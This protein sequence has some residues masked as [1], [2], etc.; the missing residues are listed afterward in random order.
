MK[1]QNIRVSVIIPCHNAE[2][3]ILKAIN[4]VLAGSVLPYEILVYD[5]FSEDRTVKVIEENFADNELVSLCRG[6]KNRGAGFARQEL[7]LKAKGNFIAFL[8]AD[9]WWYPTKLEQ[10]ISKV[11]SENCDIV[12]CG[13]D[14]FSEYGN[15]L[16]RRLPLSA[17]NVW[18]MHLSN[19]LA[20]SMTIFRK[21][22]CYATEMPQ[23]RKRQD[24]GFW[25]KIFK[26]NRKLTCSVIKE[27]L[28]GYL[29]RSNS[30]S[31]DKFDNIRHNYNMFREVLKYNRF[32]SGFL[33]F[34]NIIVRLL[35]A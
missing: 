6:T 26:N 5:D 17:I 23:I 35:R 20:T 8:D 3:T 11:L 34:L 29:R 19:W 33:V 21:D 1:E 22:L 2:R 31:S 16:G 10:Q 13:Y 9:D 15:N 14:I 18:T 28:G 12:T 25:L 32:F 24:Y 7:L 30:L 27:P 4:S